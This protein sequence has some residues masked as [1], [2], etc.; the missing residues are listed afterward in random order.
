MQPYFTTSPHL[1]ACGCGQ[2][3]KPGCIFV[4]W[5]H[6]RIKNTKGNLPELPQYHHVCPVCKKAFT[7]RQG[8]R[9]HP[10]VHCSRQCANKALNSKTGAESPS[11]K[12]GRRRLLTGYIVVRVD[13]KEVMEHRHVM[14]MRLKRCLT[15][16]EVV[17]H[18]N[19]QRDDNHVENLVVLSKP[20]HDALSTTIRW[21]K[22]KI[23]PLEPRPRTGTIFVCPVC[24][25][26]HYEYPSV[27]KQR[28]AQFC[29]THRKRGR[30]RTLALNA[31]DCA[32]CG[33]GSLFSACRSE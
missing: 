29:K 10:P 2:H 16:D 26:K 6:L 23:K 28:S 14:E 31:S 1:C 4:R 15:R 8:D 19:G 9:G 7:V 21:Q 3:L 12:G 33:N 5:H 32:P 25:I 20:R 17:H 11:W 27:S 22:G 30:P 18:I 13:G 24:A